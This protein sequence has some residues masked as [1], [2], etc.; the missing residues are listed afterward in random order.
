MHNFVSSSLMCSHRC[1]IAFYIAWLV[2]KMVS[3]MDRA[4]LALVSVLHALVIVYGCQFQINRD[5]ADEEV[6]Y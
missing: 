5:S 1:P 2:D 6:R 4:K 3:K